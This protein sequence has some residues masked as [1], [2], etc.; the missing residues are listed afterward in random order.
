[1]GFPVGDTIGIGCDAEIEAYALE[2]RDGVGAAQNHRYFAR[3][4]ARDHGVALQGLEYASLDEGQNPGDRRIR[5]SIVGT[6][7]SVGVGDRRLAETQGEGEEPIGRINR[8]Q[9]SGV[10]PSRATFAAHGFEVG[11]VPEEGRGPGQHLFIVEEK[12]GVEVER[13]GPNLAARRRRLAVPF[14]TA[15][16]ASSLSRGWRAFDSMRSGTLSDWIMTKI[17]RPPAAALDGYEAS[18]ACPEHRPFSPSLRI[19]SPNVRSRP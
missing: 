5:P 4:E 14:S 8:F 19:G 15:R 12:L 18:T 2:L 3:G 1:M 6:D 7:S 13:H 9:E 16:L 10:F 17:R 11:R